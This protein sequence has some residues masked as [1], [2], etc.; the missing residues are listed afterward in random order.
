MI[1]IIPMLC[2]A[3]IAATTTAL[4]AAQN[5]PSRPIRLMV[6]YGAGS[7]GDITARI[8]TQKMS[9]NMGQGIVVD[10]RPSAGLIIASVLAQGSVV[11][12]IGMVVFGVALGLGQPRLPA[13]AC[14]PRRPRTGTPRCRHPASASIAGRAAQGIRSASSAGG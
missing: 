4:A 2:L 12:A 6:T 8:V 5:Y 7:I 11:K 9:E 3:A 1:R 14:L 10:N 13:C